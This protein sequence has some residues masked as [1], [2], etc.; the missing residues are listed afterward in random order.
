MVRTT[1]SDKNVA[2]PDR[3]FSWPVFLSVIIFFGSLTLGFYVFDYA[4]ASFAREG[5]TSRTCGLAALTIAS[6]L[7]MIACLVFWATR[8]LKTTITRRR[9]VAMRYENQDPDS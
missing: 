3:D 5:W 2:R 4:E 6:F 9:R 7:V 1:S 8:I